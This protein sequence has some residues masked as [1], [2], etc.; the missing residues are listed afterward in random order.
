MDGQL[1]DVSAAGLRLV[2]GEALR[3]GQII[4]VETDQHLILAEVRNCLVRGTNFGIGAERVHSAAK[5][6][7]PRTSTKIGRN[8]V[9]I[10]D[11]HRR[12][13]DELNT[14]PD[15][16][17]VKPTGAAARFEVHL[18]AVAATPALPPVL[19]APPMPAAR[20]VVLPDAARAAG[21]PSQGG[22]L[23]PELTPPEPYEIGLEPLPFAEEPLPAPANTDSRPLSPLAADTGVEPLLSG[24]V[25]EMAKAEAELGENAQIPPMVAEAALSAATAP[26]SP[27]PPA[28]DFIREAARQSARFDAESPTNFRRS[29]V[30]AVL[31]AASL[32]LAAVGVLLY[33]PFAKR[34]PVLQTSAS[35]KASVAKAPTVAVDS[36]VPQPTPAATPVATP[37]KRPGPPPGAQVPGMP[38]P[39]VAAPLSALVAGKARATITASDRS[40]VTACADGN[41]VFSKLFTAG[42]K[43]NV[44]FTRRAVVRMGNAGPL[45]IL[46]NGKTMG[47]L[48]R[49]GQVRVIELTP[50]ASHFLMP[51]E[52]GDCTA[53]R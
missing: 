9:L 46:V 18:S 29:R 40:W 17:G 15:R 52:P 34:V 48:G 2:V 41:L 3:D 33:G 49:P 7:L 6:A 30:M 24:P 27:E 42:S 35:S 11:F 16:V 5:L 31:I 22:A 45:E 38:V 53:G 36:A 44:D 8:Q 20:S 19:A 21:A 50:E 32:T 39:K 12:L 1:I 23:F 51:G 28:T 37:A 43:D 25:E 26:V 47:P 4:T 14:V 10:E 13:R